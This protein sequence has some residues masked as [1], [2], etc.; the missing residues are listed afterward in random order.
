MQLVFNQNAHILVVAN[1]SLT[2]A[3]MK[4]LALQTLILVPL[5]MFSLCFT[6]QVNID[7]LE[8]VWNNHEEADSSR[9]KAVRGVVQ[10]GYLFSRPDT[11]FDIAQAMYELA[12]STDYQQWKEAARNYQG[13][14]L[15]TQGNHQSAI[16]YFGYCLD[17]NEKSGNQQQIAG[18]LNN[19]GLL[20]SEIDEID[21]AIEYLDRAMEIYEETDDTSGHALLSGNISMLLIE[22]GNFNN[23]ALELGLTSLELFQVTNDTKGVGNAYSSLGLIY[24]SKGDQEKKDGL[25]DKARLSY[26]TALEY[27]EEALPIREEML[28]KDGIAVTLQGMAEVLMEFGK[29]RKAIALLER[30]L[31]LAEEVNSLTAIRDATEKL[32]KIYKAKNLYKKAF[33]KYEYFNAINDTILS[34]E[35]KR[36]VIRQEFDHAYQEQMLA[37]SLVQVEKS[38]QVALAHQNE[39]KEKDNARNIFLGLGII[40][41]LIAFGLWSRNRYMKRVNDKLAVAKQRAEQSEKHKEQF[42]A[43]MSHE[44]RTPMHAISGMLQIIKRNEHPVSQDVYL[45]AISKSSEK[46][47]V[48][49]N[50]VL[51]LSKIEAGM[52]T[53]ESA[54]MKPQLV[55]ENV[56]QILHFKA[57][58]KGL[59]LTSDIKVDV[60]ELVMGDSARLNQILLNLVG[61]AIKFTEKGNINISLSRTGGS[62]KF[63]IKD[64]GIGI[65]ED[66]LSSVFAAFEQASK[67]TTRK[68]GGTGLGLN[69]SQQLV[70]MQDGKI[71]VESEVG[72][73][74]KFYFEL[75]LIKVSINATSDDE[76]ITEDRLKTMAKSLKGMRILLAEDNDFNQIIASDDLNF[77]IEDLHLD[78]VENGAQALSKAKTGQYDVILMDVQMPEM[79]GFDATREI[80]VFETAENKPN[81]SIVAMTVSLLESEIDNCYKAGMDDCIP[82]PY[83]PEQLISV[84]YSASQKHKA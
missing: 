24:R 58:E 64:T 74:S 54:P 15:A 8:T 72:V 71:W 25:T 1:H 35:N 36:G 3:K 33:I 59:V 30:S 39:I 5:F 76:L 73:G 68:H 62:L 19:I 78:I 63:C 65:P 81:I 56:S 84:L 41:I 55:V 48:I 83:T 10:Y 12:D 16:K 28:D 11:A 21:H 82:K 60:P 69:I 9:L 23:R 57:L 6:A 42:L 49:L 22:R 17:L 51:D 32:T 45:D 77:H 26:Q 67:T 7:S 13:I 44:I 34:E 29:E 20:Y 50:D 31:A 66:K 14:S 4:K 2:I 27:Y 61:N 79:D 38:F 40:A 53:I 52:L 43:N 18:S 70:K 47:V 80:R 37:D 46:L 75:P